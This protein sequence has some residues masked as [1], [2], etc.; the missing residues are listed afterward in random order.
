MKL[1][2]RY[3]LAA[4]FLSVSVFA[5]GVG[6]EVELAQFMNARG[7]PRFT[8]N[9]NNYKG[10]LSKSTKGKV[11]QVKHFYSGN[12]AFLLKVLDGP[13]AGQEVWVHFNPENPSL[14]LAGEDGKTVTDVD[15]AATGTATR[16]V[17]VIRD[18][19]SASAAAA[20]AR[21]PTPPAPAAPPAVAPPEPVAPAPVV[22][23]PAAPVVTT[24][25]RREAPPVVSDPAPPS[26]P[27]APSV[28]PPTVTAPPSRGSQ[29]AAGDAAGS[30]AGA[31]TAG[32]NGIV[33]TEPGEGVYTP[34]QAINDV[35][36]DSLKFV[37]RGIPNP[38]L[39]DGGRVMTEGASQYCVFKNNKV[40][41]VHQGCRPTT[42]QAV[43]V[44]VMEVF[45]R[46]GQ[47]IKFYLEPNSG[48]YSLADAGPS[49]SGSW[50]ITLTES[51]EI[52]SEL[53]LRNFFDFY[54]NLPTKSCSYGAPSGSETHTA[55][56]FCGGMTEPA[57]WREPTA[58]FYNAP[59]NF[60]FKEA[61]DAIRFKS[62]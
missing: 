4:L 7:G 35:L 40:Y 36:S 18:P 11:L 59:L 5:I 33:S 41:V 34:Q 30:A 1:N 24:P 17:P 53:S 55:Q 10:V 2:I 19:A 61:H 47:S 3:F 43:S 48:S 62:R 27:A 16:D 28:N 38:I 13:M 31:G 57:G 50:N 58:N 45:S 25:P 44:L 22:S 52:P 56:V 9:A 29:P 26:E 20:P 46:N 51:P 54:N 60:K 8:R 32:G 14:I 15:K 42:S 49:F 6:D 21:P 39:D 12:S 23:A 37:G